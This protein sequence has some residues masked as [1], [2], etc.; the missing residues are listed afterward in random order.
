MFFQLSQHFLSVGKTFCLLS[1]SYKVI[2]KNAVSML[3]NLI[4]RFKILL[5]QAVDNI[6]LIT[7]INYVMFQLDGQLDAAHETI[8]DYQGTISK[9]RDLVGN[10][11]VTFNLPVICMY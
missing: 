5:N 10:L 6:A 7:L 3:C 2:C 11:Q 8:N 4:Y 1:L 9:F